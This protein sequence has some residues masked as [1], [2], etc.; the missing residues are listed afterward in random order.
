MGTD[1]GKVSEESNSTTGGEVCD[2]V[3]LKWFRIRVVLIKRPEPAGVKASKIR[4]NRYIEVYKRKKTGVKKSFVTTF[5]YIHQPM[6]TLFKVSGLVH[7]SETRR[8]LFLFPF[9]QR[10]P[11]T[12]A[13]TK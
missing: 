13:Y 3:R 4:L 8:T 12:R 9:V 11:E 6:W 1:K 7:V 2:I 5:I 10:I